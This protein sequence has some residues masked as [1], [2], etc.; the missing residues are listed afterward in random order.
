MLKMAE[1]FAALHFCSVDFANHS[2]LLSGQL[3]LSGVFRFACQR[4]APESGL[5]FIASEL[6]FP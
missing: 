6:Y 5:V 4:V 3:A 2:R 1:I